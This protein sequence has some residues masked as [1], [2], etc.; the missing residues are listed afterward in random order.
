MQRGGI[1][2]NTELSTPD[3]QSGVW[4]QREGMEPTQGEWD[5]HCPTV[6]KPGPLPSSS[7]AFA[8]SMT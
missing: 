1:G 8:A 7:Q 6:T 3:S 2:K 5:P 4:E